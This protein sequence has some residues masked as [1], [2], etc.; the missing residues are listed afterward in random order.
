MLIRA[1]VGG[2]LTVGAIALAR[3]PVDLIGLRLLQG[4]VSGTVAATTTLVASGTPR[5][6]VGPAM[7]ILSSAIAMG[8][9]VGP[10][11]GGVAAS[12]IGL[13]NV[14]LFGGAMLLLAVVPVIFLVREAPIVKVP[15]A[16]IRTLAAIRA[17]G[18]GAF[19]AIAVLLVAQ[20]LLQVSWSGSQPLVALKLLE[21]QPNNTTTVTGI[22]FAVS[23]VASAVAGISYSRL[24]ASSGYRSV[25]GVAAVL[26][27]AALVLLGVATTVLLVILA[28]FLIGLFIGA[29]GPATSTMLGLEAPRQVQGRIFGLSASATA[30]GFGLGPLIGGTMAGV[31]TVSAALYTTAAIALVLGAVMAFGAREPKR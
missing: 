3:G 8:S 4:A 10:F 24:V 15:G 12:Y 25:S 31:V 9:A 14:F 13:R 2:G 27:A 26:T 7:G 16:P 18:P 23:G 30:V 1:M 5:E 17:A 28:T 20:A 29:L 21:L 6:K 19:A 22:A 11:V